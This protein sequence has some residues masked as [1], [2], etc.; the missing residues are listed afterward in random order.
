MLVSSKQRGHQKTTLGNNASHS[1]MFRPH[2]VIIRLI[3]SNIL[4][5]FLNM[6]LDVSLTGSKRVDE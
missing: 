2:R 5:K 1:Y 6:F 4:R 3:F